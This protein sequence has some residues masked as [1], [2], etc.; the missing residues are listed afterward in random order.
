[1]IAMNEQKE[2][3][4]SVVHDVKRVD[5]KPECHKKKENKPKRSKEMI[6]KISKRLEL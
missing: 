6:P 2:S 3:D 4:C 1:M 5:K